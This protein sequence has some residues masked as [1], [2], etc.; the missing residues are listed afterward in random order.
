MKYQQS[1]QSPY[2]MVYIYLDPGQQCRVERGAIVYYN[3]GITVQGK[4]NA[5]TEDGSSVGNFFKAVGRSLSSG[6][7]F[8][9]TNVS[10]TA[11]GSMVAIAPPTSGQIIE[12]Q[13]SPNQTWLV[14]DGCFL[15]CDPTVQYKMKKQKVKNSFL[16]TGGHW[17]MKTEGE[18]TM[19]ING[20]GDV[21]PIDLDGSA[22]VIVDNNNIVAWESTLSY[23]SKHCSGTLGFRS[24][25]G[26]VCHFTGKGRIYIMTRTYQQFAN[27]IQRYLPSNG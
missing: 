7:S 6:E 19:L 20:F 2:S 1:S 11:H 21:V 17:I 9:M 22:P 16:G 3:M 24:G 18:G 12:L 13:V 26:R 15:A 23:E 25:E 10:S 8:W 5:G 14:N 27:E 4:M